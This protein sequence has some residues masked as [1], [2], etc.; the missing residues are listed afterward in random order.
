MTTRQHLHLVD[1]VDPT[2][3]HATRKP[4]TSRAAGPGTAF[5]AAW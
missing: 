5:S 1:V 2:P 3:R 4:Q